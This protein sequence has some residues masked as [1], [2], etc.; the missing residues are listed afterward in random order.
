[1]GD[2]IYGA[3]GNLYDAYG[4]QVYAV[5]GADGNLYSATGDLLQ[6]NA[7][8]SDVQAAASSGLWGTVSDMIKQIPSLAAGL[9][10]LQIQQ[11]NVQRAKQGLA[12]LNA[13]QYAP[14]VG[15]N[16]GASTMNMLLLAA[17]GIGAVMLLKR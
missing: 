11:L 17:L 13:A 14:Q 5:V 6:V 15:V 12:P 9:T 16:L 2:L 8:A 10:A 7:S 4:N 3:D 1:M